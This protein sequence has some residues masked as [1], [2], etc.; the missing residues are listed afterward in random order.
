MTLLN[1]ITTH[2]TPNSL[3]SILTPEK[4]WVQAQDIKKSVMYFLQSPFTSCT[5]GQNIVLSNFKFYSLPHVLITSG[6]I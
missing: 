5:L 6:G 3:F 1:L 4:F 2:A